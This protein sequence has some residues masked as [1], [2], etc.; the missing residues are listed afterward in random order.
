MRVTRG[1]DTRQ[2]YE[3]RGSAFLGERIYRTPPPL[4]ARRYCGH[5]RVVSGYSSSKGVEEVVVPCSVLL[6]SIL[7]SLFRIPP[8]AHPFRSS[9]SLWMSESASSGDNLV[10]DH[11]EEVC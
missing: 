2:L 10:I 6:P 5:L 4:A 11:E 1:D 7:F 9:A 8:R 3:K